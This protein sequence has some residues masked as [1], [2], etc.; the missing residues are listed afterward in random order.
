MDCESMASISV[1]FPPFADE[2]AEIPDSINIREIKPNPFPPR[3]NVLQLITQALS[4]PIGSKPLREL[5]SGKY[6]LIPP[7]WREGFQVIIL[8]DD[9]TRVTPVKVLLPPLLKEIE[10]IGIK[11]FQ[12]TLIVAGGSHRPMTREELMTK[13]GKNI[14]DQYQVLLH[15]WNH[16]AKMVNL[17][18]TSRGI[19]IMVNPLVAQADFKIALGNI[20]PHEIAGFAGG[21]KMI[22]PG[23]STLQ[24]VGQVHWL[25]TG[26]PIEQRLGVIANP[27]R[28]Q[29]NE[30]GARVGLD[31]VMNTVLNHQGQVVGVFCGNP[32]EAH[33]AGCMLARDI[34]SIGAP[35]AEIVV[36]DAVPEYTDFW[37]CSKAALHAKGFV[38]KGG[39]LIVIAACTEGICRTHPQIL[40]MGYQCPD[41]LE[42]QYLQQSGSKY[43]R[44]SA[45]H[46][47][48][49]WE[50]QQHC[51]LFLVTRGIAQQDA[52]KL[53]ITWF[54]T[55]QAAVKQA[56]VQKP[57]ATFINVLQ[58]GA[59]IMQKR[60]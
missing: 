56:L 36:T 16:D 24:T 23:V 12:V 37:T 14:L 10:E 51:S 38:K 39:V 26:I 20:I 47:A 32:V 3:A 18:K 28:D 57:K 19:E 4:H 55:L 33:V 13:F 53:G 34:Y 27:V 6:S 21:Y 43:N 11:K 58:H 22:I 44:L 15:D 8:V 5:L 54:D 45:T 9:H 50:I 17:G 1:Q 42:Q 40:E 48:N 49:L 60:E 2:W 52:K 31:F 25:S 7:L 59:E 30:G 35:P 46:C 41:A 29:I